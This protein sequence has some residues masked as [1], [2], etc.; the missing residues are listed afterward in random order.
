MIVPKLSLRR[1]VPW[2]SVHLTKLVFR[3]LKELLGCHCD[4]DE[5]RQPRH[6]LLSQ[7]CRNVNEKICIEFLV[8]V[9][10]GIYHRYKMFFFYYY[11]CF[12]CL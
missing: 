4:S 6:H 12:E 9:T 7:D 8:D 5:K 10:F 11:H 1:H 3:G 2:K